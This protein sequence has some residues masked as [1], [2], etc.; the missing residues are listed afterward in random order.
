MKL[1]PPQSWRPNER[2]AAFTVLSLLLLALILLLSK[3]TDPLSNTAPW[4]VMSEWKEISAV[5]DRLNTSDGV[6][7]I[8]VPSMIVTENFVASVMEIQLPVI[9]AALILSLAGLALTLAA[10]TALPRFWYIGAMTGFM[11]LLAFSGTEML[12]VDFI[13]P[14]FLFLLILLVTGGLSYYMHAFR[15]DLSLPQRAVLMLGAVFSLAGFVWLTCGAEY[16]ALTAMVYGMP[17]WLG[18]AVVFLFISATEVLAGLVWLCTVKSSGLSHRSFPAFLTGSLLYLILLVLLFL[19]NTRQLDAEIRLVSPLV[20]AIVGGLAGITGFKRRCDATGGALDYRH[21]GWMLYTGLFIIALSCALSQATLS[22]DPVLEVLE[23]TIVNTQLAMGIVFV[24]YVLLNFTPLFR[25][26]LEVYKVLYKPMRFDLTKTRLIGFGGVIALFSM[27]N[28]FPLTQGI[29]GYFNGLG[30]LHTVTQEYT[31]A[32]QY[33]KMALKHEFQNHKSNYALASLALKQ[34]DQTAAAYYFRQATLKNPS[35]QAFVGLGNV[36]MRENLYFDAL[37]TLQNAHR[38]FPSNGEISNNLGMLFD[39][40]AVADSAYYYLELSERQSARPEVAGS[41][42]LAVLAGNTA[43]TL[44]DSLAGSLKDRDYV[45]F[46]AN[47]LTIRN[48]SGKFEKENFNDNWIPQD[49]LL[50][51]ATFAY[52]YNFCLNQAKNGSEPGELALAMAMKNPLIANELSLAAVYPQFYS[53]DKLRAIGLLQSWAKEETSK[54]AQFN[55]I[56]GHWWLQLGV[57]SKAEEAFATIAGK[58]GILGQIFANVLQ[59]KQG[60]A[61]ILLENLLATEEGQADTALRLLQDRLEQISSVPSEADSLLSLAISSRQEK[62][63]QMALRANPLNGKVV[64]AVSDFYLQQG[65]LEKAYEIV[66]GALLYNEEDPWLW[67]QFAL[68]ALKQ[69][70]VTDAEEA[71]EKAEAGLPL[72]DYQRFRQEY[73]AQRTLIEKERESFK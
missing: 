44:R 25:K 73:Q 64:G 51:V 59:G 17:L 42:L 40:S 23:D 33:Y 48:L 63:F 36:L 7:G 69:G 41:N 19:K 72:A 54:S 12:H 5:I 1:F 3:I 27:Q 10:I 62:D 46:R 60:S 56:A 26:R 43:G 71:A 18:L 37:F 34:D 66:T 39:R 47:K 15:V 29:A 31:L 35:P 58:E 52:L 61:G 22:N 4:G 68:L 50:S 70:L 16:P 11:I 24:F 65:Q 67:R 9:L 49:S 13:H 14:R 53:G 38:V 45:S 8:P 30:D 20:P 2:I 6:F 55:L 57:F 32:E 21:G 28:L